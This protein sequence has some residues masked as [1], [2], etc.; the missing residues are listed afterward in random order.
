MAF[1]CSP[2]CPLE[3]FLWTAPRSDVNR[4]K[5]FF[6]I[7]EIVLVSVKGPENEDEKISERNQLKPKDVITELLS[8]ARW[9]TF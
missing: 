2:K 4:Q 7:Y 5:K 8:I 3:L 1:D 6:E 9:E